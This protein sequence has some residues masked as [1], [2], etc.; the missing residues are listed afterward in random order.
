MGYN[1]NKGTLTL[2]VYVFYGCVCHG[3]LLTAAL[4]HLPLYHQRGISE[5]EQR[6]PQLLKSS[7]PNNFFPFSDREKDGCSA[8]LPEK[9]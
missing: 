2:T 3:V 6:W 7:R 9:G 8:K 5:H 4:Y 1:V